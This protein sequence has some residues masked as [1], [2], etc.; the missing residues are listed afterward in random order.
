MET[1][2]FKSF[3][4]KA[5]ALKPCCELQEYVLFDENK[6]IY[7]NWEATLILTLEENVANPIVISMQNLK[8]FCSKFPNTEF[9]INPI[10]EKEVELS[11]NSTK[12]KFTNGIEFNEIPLASILKPINEKLPH[13]NRTILTKKDITTIKRCSRY[14]LNN[15]LR[16]TLE[17]VHINQNNIFASDAYIGTMVSREF[18]DSEQSAFVIPALYTVM[19]DDWDYTV[20]LTEKDSYFK[21]DNNIDIIIHKENIQPLDYA[22]I[23]P[24]IKDHKFSFTL[25]NKQIS[26]IEKDFSFADT[27]FLLLRFGKS[28]NGIMV[29]SH[30]DSI[31]ISKEIKDTDIKGEFETFGLSYCVLMKLFKAEKDQEIFTFYEFAPH[32]PLLVNNTT[33]LIMPHIINE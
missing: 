29:S 12:I 25:T 18:P 15:D 1:N 26:E 16:P 5:S 33:T 13:E 31:Q 27:K 19:F 4:K 10:S 24:D 2:D 23:L 30:N 22:S 9:Y 17:C 28:D 14:T 32:M 7:S 8:S 6:A 21:S 3:I 11:Y 20:S